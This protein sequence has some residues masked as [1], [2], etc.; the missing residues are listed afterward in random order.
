MSI[1]E[2]RQRR[3]FYVIVLNRYIKSVD[4]NGVSDLDYVH[5]IMAAIEGHTHKINRSK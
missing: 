5:R 2:L 3:L 1:K 4:V